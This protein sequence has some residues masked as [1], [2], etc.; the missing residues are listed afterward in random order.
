MKKLIDFFKRFQIFLLFAALQFI[1]LSNYFTSLSFPRSQYLTTANTVAGSLW[2]VQYNF[3]KFV[4]LEE[5]NDQLV[6]ANK[7][8]MEKQPESFVRLSSQ[9][10]T[11]EDTLYRQQYTYLPG[12][13]I[14]STYAKENNF[15]TLNMGSTLGIE[16]GMGV[17]NELG[18]VGIVHSVSKHFSIVKSLLSQN[19]NIDVKIEKEEAI[20]NGEAFGL[21]K[22]ETHDPRI[23]NINGISNDLTIDTNLSVVTRGGGGIFPRGIPVGVI[24]TFYNVEGKPLWDVQVKLAVDFR[25][26]QKVYVIKNLLK[27]EQLNLESLI[28]ADKN[29]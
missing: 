12:T 25:S 14:N 5:T 10:F 11:I 21:M 20:E 18:V 19:I 16:K 27:D 24:S 8:L 13:V 17:F 1:A 28:P 23:A 26:I 29:D 3:M 22:W 2:A 4:R 7:N 6:K 15:L 9:T